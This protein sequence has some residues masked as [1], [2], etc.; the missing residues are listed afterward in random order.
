LAAFGLFLLPTA[1]G[2][3]ALALFLGLAVDYLLQ[4]GFECGGLVG[5]V[6]PVR[7]RGRVRGVADQ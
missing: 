3:L 5:G 7:A 6:A 4:L 1:F 2:F